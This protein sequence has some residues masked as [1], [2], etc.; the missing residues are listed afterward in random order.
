M[1]LMIDRLVSHIQASLQII[2]EGQ[3]LVEERDVRQYIP[4]DDSWWNFWSVGSSTIWDNACS[5]P[6]NVRTN[7]SGLETLEEL[8]LREKSI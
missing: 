2:N 3:Y 8:T 4:T 1:A 7:R 6:N 5:S